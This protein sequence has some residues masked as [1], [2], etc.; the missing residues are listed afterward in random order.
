MFS[1]LYST[2]LANLLLGATR[3]KK[4]ERRFCFFR[5]L[6]DMRRTLFAGYSY[7]IKPKIEYQ[8][9]PKFA[10]SKTE[11]RFCFFRNL[12]D[13]GEGRF[14]P[15]ALIV[16]N[17]KSPQIAFLKPFVVLYSDAGLNFGSRFEC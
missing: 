13:M 12:S 9:S 2:L 8:K 1:I 7:H 11:R 10:F 6:S 3:E 17:Q 16:L 5:N 15:D 4:A 14:L